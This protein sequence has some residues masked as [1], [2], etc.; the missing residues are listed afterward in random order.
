MYRQSLYSSQ[1]SQLQ[2]GF[3]RRSVQPEH[4]GLKS[5]TWATHSNSSASFLLG[6]QDCFAA[7]FLDLFLGR[8]GELVGVHRDRGGQLTI[9]QDLDQAIALF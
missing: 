5:E 2:V 1:P 8:L 4:P 6:Y 3:N 7:G 9:T